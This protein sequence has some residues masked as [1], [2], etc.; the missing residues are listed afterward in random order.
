MKKPG[1]PADNR[2]RKRRSGRFLWRMLWAFCLWA[3]LPGIVPN[4]Q[5]VHATGDEIPFVPGEVLVGLRQGDAGPQMEGRQPASLASLA[6]EAVAPL[7]LQGAWEAVSGLR[8]TVPVGQE[9]TTIQRL[10]ADPAVVFAEPNWLVQA[11][12]T[13]PLATAG[14]ETP[15]PFAPNDPLYD[16]RQW[17][18]QRIQA[19]R[20]WTLGRGGAVQVAVVDSG[21]DFSHPEFQNRLLDGQNYVTPFTAPEDDSGHGTHVTGIVAAELNNGTGIAGLAPQVLIDPRKV[22]DANNSGS[23]ANVAQAIRDAT[24]AGAQ[25]INLSLESRAPSDVLEAAVNYAAGRGVLLVASVGNRGIQQVE[26]PAAYT[27]VLAVA[28][29]DR[30]DQRTFYSNYGPQ[31]NIAAPGGLSAD[32]IYSTWPFGVKCDTAV[33]SGYCALVGTSMSAAF[34]SGA[35]ALVW[36]MRPDLSADAV[37][38][39]LLETAYPTGQSSDFVGAGR[40]DVH[41]AARRAEPSDLETSPKRF[42]FL[43]KEGAEIFTRTITLSNP[44]SE[45]IT[46]QAS[47]SGGSHWLTLASDTSGSVHYTQPI[48]LPLAISPTQLLPGRYTGSVSVRAERSNGSQIVF[49][50]PVALTIVETVHRYHLPA[51]YRDAPV[52][53]W[54]LPDAQGRETLR[55]L[56]DSNTG[57][58]LPFTYTLDSRQYNTIRLYSDGFLAFPA[59]ENGPSLPVHCLADETWAQQ[60]IY[61]WWTDLDPG[62]AGQIST[63]QPDPDRFVIEFNNVPTAAGI[64][65]AYAVSFQIVLSKSGE[66]RINYRD[67]PAEAGN[68]VVG[69]E[70]RDSLVYNQVACRTET[71]SLGELPGSGISLLIR[72]TDLR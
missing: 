22:L 29:T 38:D 1:F 49:S 37:K 72:P 19:S 30:F 8:L 63:F 27:N 50:L 44:S 23:I 39:I 66:V 12:D 33:A 59:G 55:L 3:L 28:A 60:A 41:A 58:L 45:P 71:T 21:I 48:Q 26:W 15:P 46:W 31:V 35:A 25:V 9:W 18:M 16:P 56:D 67:T 2:K 69:M 11:S 42:D 47:I 24:D 57:L 20:A 70:A 17:G 7:N 13:G 62:S 40:L 68:V 34:V 6:V 5:A 36:G 32:L 14:L 52:P 64:A 53:Q 51:V 61:G 4:T 54:A 10:R 65:P 43:L